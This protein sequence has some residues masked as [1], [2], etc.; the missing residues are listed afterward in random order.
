[1]IAFC[2]L[3]CSD[4]YY[5]CCYC[6][7]WA[8]AS[9]VLTLPCC[10]DHHSNRRDLRFRLV[11][12]TH[13][14][15]PPNH[16][17]SVYVFFYISLSF[18]DNN[19]HIAS[20]DCISLNTATVNM[21][22]LPFESP[23]YFLSCGANF[24]PTTAAHPL[25]PVICFCNRC[26]FCDYFVTLFLTGYISVNTA[27]INTNFVPFEPPRS[28]LSFDANFV[29]PTGTHPLPPL[30]VVHSHHFSLPFFAIFSQSFKRCYLCQYCGYEYEF[31]IIRTALI[32][33]FHRCQFCPPTPPPATA[34]PPGPPPPPPP[35]VA[36]HRHLPRPQPRLVRGP[37]QLAAAHAA[38]QDPQ[39]AERANVRRPKGEIDR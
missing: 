34:T 12:N 25:P 20:N 38:K 24:V 5:Y 18:F 33:S 36:P 11:P 10:N 21:D 27:F 3:A 6:T 9:L 30:Y 39:G 4:Y 17:H 35:Q 16:C 7:V 37:V 32:S 15:L 23:C 22:F 29:T 1:M 31:H 14:L 26:L 19:S 28:P 13:R 8:V 2:C